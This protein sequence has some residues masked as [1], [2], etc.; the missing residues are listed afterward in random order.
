MQMSNRMLIKL[1][2]VLLATTAAASAAHAERLYGLGSGNS[3]VSFDSATPGTTTTRAITGV[4]AG[5]TLVGIDLRPATRQ[6]FTV[7]TS[8]NV[9]SLR[10]TAGGFAATNVGSSNF[11]PSGGN[12]G[13]DFN[14]TVDRIRVVS[15]TNQNL[16]LNPGSPGTSLNDSALT[17]N[18]SS[19]F[20]LVAVAY[21]NNDNDPL[22]GTVLYGLDAVSGGLVRST[23]AN[24]GTYANT[25][26]AGVAFGPLGTAIGSGSVDFDISGVTGIGYFQAGD[27]LHTIDFTT[28]AGSSIGA[29][30]ATGISGLTA[31]GV[32]EP[33]SWAL[34][35]VGFGLTGAVMRRRAP[36]IRSALANC[37]RS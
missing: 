17:L 11:A 8:G 14:P 34:L 13:I 28:G 10:A 4:A 23:N 19:N 36:A 20:D 27:V 31:G 2:S 18:G 30:G 35:I 5:D 9:Y 16:R 29:I 6:L 37:F 15:D 26:L 3:I 7:G 21:S 25:N 32:P 1:A 24:A 22:T 12:F 33:S